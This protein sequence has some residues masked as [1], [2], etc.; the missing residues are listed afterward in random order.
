MRGWV[1]IRDL[2][3]RGDGL[4][5]CVVERFAVLTWSLRTVIKDEIS[6]GH[7]GERW[8]SVQSQ[9]LVIWGN[10]QGSCLPKLCTVKW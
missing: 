9:F 2:E 8:P 3:P 10:F 6:S 4:W 1:Q 5:V 7:N